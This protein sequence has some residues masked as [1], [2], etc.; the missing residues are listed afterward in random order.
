MMVGTVAN[1]EYFEMGGKDMAQAESECPGWLER[2]LTD[3]VK[4]LENY[5]E[6]FAKLSGGSGAI[7]VF[8]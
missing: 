4:G 6:L 7:R 2:L 5:G 3:A 8:Y 1:L